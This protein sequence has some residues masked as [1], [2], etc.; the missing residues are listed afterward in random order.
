M[1]FHDKVGFSWNDQEIGAKA[2]TVPVEIKV[3]VLVHLIA[4]MKTIKIDFMSCFG[5]DGYFTVQVNEI[6]WESSGIDIII[7]YL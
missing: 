4:V 3:L 1:S 5:L 2:C 6:K 7:E